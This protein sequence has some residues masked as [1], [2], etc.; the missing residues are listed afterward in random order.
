[1][2]WSR[3][4]PQ[5]NWFVASIEIKYKK[6]S[7][8]RVQYQCQRESGQ[9]QEVLAPC[10]YAP[11]NHFIITESDTHWFRKRGDENGNQI[12]ARRIYIVYTS[13]HST[14]VATRIEINARGSLGKGRKFTPPVNMMRKIMP[15]SVRPVTQGGCAFGCSIGGA[16][17]G[18]SKASNWDHA[19]MTAN[20]F[21]NPS[22]TCRFFF[23]FF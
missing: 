10:Q 8:H 22:F 16:H 19:M 18:S 7:L 2:E 4:L 6:K 17:V 13:T 23:F 12:N 5:R 15:F 14:N 9:G 1:M 20:P 21:R 11:E 3:L